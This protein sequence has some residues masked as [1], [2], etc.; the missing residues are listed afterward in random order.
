MTVVQERSPHTRVSIASTESESS[1]TE[2][3]Q[4]RNH[5]PVAT[6]NPESANCNPFEQP[7]EDELN[8]EKTDSSRDRA[9]STIGDAEKR[10]TGS[11]GV[12]GGNGVY[13]PSQIVDTSAEDELRN[14]RFRDRIRHFTWTWFTMTMATGGIANVL[15]TGMLTRDDNPVTYSETY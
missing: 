15:Y 13:D 3:L 4:W 6:P 12:E 5:P 9:Q 14:M 2:R 8:L 11:Q 10:N 1:A 7:R